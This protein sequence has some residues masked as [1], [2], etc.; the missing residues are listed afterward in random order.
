MTSR[1]AQRRD[2]RQR[3]ALASALDPDRRYGTQPAWA[4]D[5]ESLPEARQQAHDILVMQMGDRRAGPVEWRTYEGEAALKVIGEYGRGY[6][7][8]SYQASIVRRMRGHL[9]EYGGFIVIALAPE[10][11]APEPSSP[12]P[13]VPIV[14]T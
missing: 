4:M 7:P 8:D 14:S 1:R 11:P 9:R 10:K 2:R 5:A 13:E 6:A 12:E 3:N